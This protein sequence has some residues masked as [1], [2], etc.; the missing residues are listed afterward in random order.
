M[1]T[2]VPNYG[3]HPPY[4][5]KSLELVTKC[6]FGII[7]QYKITDLA[8]LDKPSLIWR[9]V[10]VPAN[11]LGSWNCE[12]NIQSFV[13]DV[14]RDAILLSG[15]DLDVFLEVKLS[16]TDHLIPDVVIFKKK[17]VIVG[18]CEVKQPSM[19]RDDLSHS[20]L[21]DQMGNYC[22]VARNCLGLLM[23]IGIMTT[24][25]EW[26]ICWLSSADNI[27]NATT[28][29]DI[30]NLNVSV[31]GAEAE[32]HPKFHETDVFR[33]DNPA[34]IEA[35]V[36]AVIKMNNVPIAPTRTILQQDEGGRRKFG[37]ANISSSTFI[38][39]VLPSEVSKLSFELPAPQS[40]NYY[41]LQDFHGGA[42]GRVWLSMNGKGR[43]C[44][45]KFS[46]SPDLLSGEA[47][48]WNEV[49]GI[50]A[51]NIRLLDSPAM[52]MPFVFHGCILP[53][54]RVGFRP[55]GSW[56]SGEF[57]VDS[58]LN[59]AEVDADFDR[60]SVTEYYNDPD[61][62]ARE[63]LQVLAHAG[64]Q[65]NDLHWRHVALLPYKDDVLS[66][67][68]WKVRPILIDVCRLTAID[69]KDVESVIHYGLE[70]LK[71]ELGDDK[72]ED[73]DK[74]DDKKEDDK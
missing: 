42:D 45:L 61:K 37:C 48:I 65:H 11:S 46:S 49:W 25:N 63:A 51:R 9:R 57:N 16:I 12:Q 23:P 40:K 56:L 17:G 72:K 39:S 60:K 44:V 28:M 5:G 41:L 50:S 21:R 24:Y 8:K 34:L 32:D 20:T 47:K 4:L 2:Q 6:G 1:S 53:G 73:K 36:S 26:K 52:L 62:V 71:V 15:C 66:S 68:K 14:I 64:Y 19:K 54:N 67:N 74:E 7:D 10:K 55:L 59:N 69:R 38:W 27:A 30:Q 58:I 18:I 22:Q 3:T 70:Q 35:L 43:L 33:Y 31:T 29:E 13:E